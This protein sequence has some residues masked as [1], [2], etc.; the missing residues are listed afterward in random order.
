VPARELA[1][2]KS[3]TL[4]QLAVAW[5]LARGGPIVPFPGCKTRAHPDER[6][7]AL[8][9][10]LTD[11]EVATLDRAFPPGVAAGDRYPPEALARWYQ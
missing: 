1:A 8:D 5:G 3:T 10:D 7:G 4:P 2:A 6:V 9:I 11:D